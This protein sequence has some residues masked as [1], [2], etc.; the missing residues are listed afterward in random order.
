MTSGL[1]M[2]KKQ[3]IESWGRTWFFTGNVTNVTDILETLVQD[4][5]T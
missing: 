1:E 4:V 5:S 3:F 2:E